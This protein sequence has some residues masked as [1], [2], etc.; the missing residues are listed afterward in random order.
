MIQSPFTSFT[1]WFCRTTGTDMILPFPPLPP[2]S[3]YRPDIQ[4]DLSESHPSLHLHCHQ[5]S[6][7]R[8]QCDCNFRCFLIFSLFPIFHTS[9]PEWS[10][11][12]QI[13]WYLSPAKAS[14]ALAASEFLYTL[15]E[16]LLSAIY[17]ILW[18]QQLKNQ[19]RTDGVM[20][21]GKISKHFE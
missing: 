9:Q 6:P 13:R 19:G 21:M 18:K 11:K 4:I 3:V 10:F 17:L 7:N 2:N 5:P 16:G 20:G 14:N 15:K 1:E 8:D 12:M